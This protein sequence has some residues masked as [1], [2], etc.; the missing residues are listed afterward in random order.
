MSNL[1]KLD[2]A[3]LDATGI[4]YH[5]WVCDVHNHLKAHEII[6]TIRKPPAAAAL[7]Q[8][9][10]AAAATTP[11][12]IATEALEDKN[13]K[14]IIIM[15]CHM[16]EFF[17]SSTSMKSPKKLW[18]ALEERFGNIIESLLPDLEVKWQQL[19][20]CDCEYNSEVLRIK[21]LMESIVFPIFNFSIFKA[22]QLG[23]W[24]S[25]GIHWP[26]CF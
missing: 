26:I 5:K 2:F 22:V 12:Q 17:N 24:W 18:V 9:E 20:F 14:T 6:Y 1:K 25:Y 11:D 19:R 21:S 23:R 10:A 13:V 3:P 15:I 16:D 4:E 8:W 7:A